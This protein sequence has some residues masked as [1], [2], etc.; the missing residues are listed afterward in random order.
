M[1]RK[2]TNHV[3]CEQSGHAHA[4]TANHRS[5]AIKIDEYVISAL[6]I[7]AAQHATVKNT[8]GNKRN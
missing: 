1:N 8:I 3:R 6:D 2:V 5:P 7:V 4:V